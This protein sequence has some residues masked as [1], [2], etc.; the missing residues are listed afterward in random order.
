MKWIAA[1]IV[2]AAIIIA[3]VI[4]TRPVTGRTPFDLKP[5]PT[6]TF[7]VKGGCVYPNG[8]TNPFFNSAAE[9]EESGGRWE[10]K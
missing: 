9:C 8:I 6:S 2:A 5:S 10:P 4:A 3:I 7:V 1:A